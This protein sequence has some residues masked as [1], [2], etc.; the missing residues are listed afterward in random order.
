MTAKIDSPDF[1]T[2]SE[3]VKAWYRFYEL[4]PR[5]GLSS[6]LC[7]ARSI[8][9]IMDMSLPMTSRP[10]SSAITWVSIPRE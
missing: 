2:M 3:A 7:Q 4:D 5:D 10:R 6:I 1:K 8:S 9:T